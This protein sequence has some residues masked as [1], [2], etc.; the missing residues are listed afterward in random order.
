MKRNIILSKLRTYN[1][2]LCSLA[3]GKLYISTINAY[4][5]TLAQRDSVF[6]AALQSSDILLPDGIGIVIAKRLLTGEKIRKIAGEDFFRFEMSRLNETSSKCLFLGSCH[7]VLDNI[8]ETAAKEYPNVRVSTY[9]P[10]FKDQFTLEDNEKMLEVINK[11]EPDVLFIGM[12]APKQ[13]KWAYENFD[14]IKANHVVCIGAVFDFYAGTVK[15]APKAVISMGMEWL[16]RLIREPK[17]L[18]RRYL[19][20]IP[21]YILIILREYFEL[22]TMPEWLHI[23]N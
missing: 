6:A 20:G 16:Y 4:S 23:K 10:P 17:R 14:Q 7:S 15:R 22:K 1:N 18:W 21:A 5:Y 2:D 3:P 19:F 8:R 13:E 9:S 12:T 11:N